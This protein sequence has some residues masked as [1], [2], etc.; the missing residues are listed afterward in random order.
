LRAAGDLPWNHEWESQPLL[1]PDTASC[2]IRGEGSRSYVMGSMCPV[3]ADAYTLTFEMQFPGSNDGKAVPKWEA[4]LAF[5]QPDDQPFRPWHKVPVGGYFLSL[6]ARGD[7]ELY[8]QEPD[9]VDPVQLTS[10]PTPAP[11][12]GNWMRF[13][14]QVTP[15]TIRIS[16]LDGQELTAEAEDK[17]YRGGYFSLYKSHAAAISADFRA[18]TLTPA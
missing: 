9:R 7:L 12:P 6:N 8:R 15:S 13:R 16:R 1:R 18:V 5:G 14:V 2:S 10:V 3:E 11:I 17:T 4:G